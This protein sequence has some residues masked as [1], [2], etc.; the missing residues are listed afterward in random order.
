[1]GFESCHSSLSQKKMTKSLLAYAFITFITVF[2]I[3]Y[4]QKKFHVFIVFY[5]LIHLNYL[6][7]KQHSSIEEF[8]SRRK[9]RV[10]NSDVRR[11]RMGDRSPCKD[12]NPCRGLRD[13]WFSLARNDT[14]SAIAV[15]KKRSVSPQKISADVSD[16]SQHFYHICPNTTLQPTKN[17]IE[18]YQNHIRS[19]QYEVLKRL[20]SISCH[21]SYV[22]IHYYRSSS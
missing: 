7:S 16:I 20:V 9:G 21:R 17:T 10:V 14:L 11:G 18:Q 12:R 6:L 8:V 19:H 1:M 13:E 15:F 5:L 2:L 22:C 3:T 4:C